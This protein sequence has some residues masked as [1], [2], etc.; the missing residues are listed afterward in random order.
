VF[1]GQR[2]EAEEIYCLDDS[3]ARG[4]VEGDVSLL[5]F[6]LYMYAR[7]GMAFLLRNAIVLLGSWGRRGVVF[8]QK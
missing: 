8:G 7:I 4:Q 6:L 1:G 2:R 3:A 5:C